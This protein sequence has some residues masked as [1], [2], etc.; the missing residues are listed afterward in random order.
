MPSAAAAGL[1]SLLIAVV[2]HAAESL[3]HAAESYVLALTKV[4]N[5][6]HGSG[7]PAAAI[8]QLCAALPATAARE[9]GPGRA[10]QGRQKYLSDLHQGLSA[11]SAPLAL[12]R[13]PL[14]ACLRACLAATSDHT[15]PTRSAPTNGPNNSAMPHLTGPILAQGR[16][17]YLGSWMGTGSRG[18]SA[19][20]WCGVSICL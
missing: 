12:G 14:A 10:A 4:C 11:A 5:G 3:C 2:C 19:P 15:A 6:L 7:A 20:R 1:S 18:L 8:N 17:A 9:A 13:P 16:R